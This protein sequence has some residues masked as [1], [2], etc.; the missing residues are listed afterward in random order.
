MK[1]ERWVGRDIRGTMK[2]PCSKSD[3]CGCLNL[4]WIADEKAWVA[5][6][7]EC[8]QEFG[9]FK[10][11]WSNP[12]DRVRLGRDPIGIP[13]NVAADLRRKEDDAAA[14]ER[15]RN[16]G[17]ATKEAQQRR[18][19]MKTIDVR[20]I[21]ADLERAAKRYM[22]DAARDRLGGKLREWFDGALRRQGMEDVV[23]IG[24]PAAVFD[25]V[26]SGD[27]KIII[28][29]IGSTKYTVIRVVGP[30]VLADVDEIRRDA[31]KFLTAVREAVNA[32]AQTL[33]L[34][35]A[36]ASVPALYVRVTAYM[37]EWFLWGYAGAPTRVSEKTGK[38]RK[39][40]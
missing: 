25:D 26:D 30:K 2:A 34:D 37:V 13:S 23:E 40:G 1:D 36:V 38:K 8:R 12:E 27:A 15:G 9:W 4:I 17:G 31:R 11:N 29:T 21:A 7:N 28:S 24:E 5:R 32:Y 35:T 18:K 33:A 14:R 39:K 6:C 3:C 16:K 10:T 19:T 20:D 22:E